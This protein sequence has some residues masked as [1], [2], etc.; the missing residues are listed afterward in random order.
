[1]S[2]FA[3]SGEENLVVCV[4]KWQCTD[5]KECT[6]GVQTRGCTDTN[7]CGTAVNKPVESRS[8]EVFKL[9]KNY[10][11]LCIGFIIVILVIAVI[12][13]IMRRKSQDKLP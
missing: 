12:F 5:W 9:T 3:V 10:W 8:C 7:N 4:E 11:L 6:E 1:L 2:T 13:L